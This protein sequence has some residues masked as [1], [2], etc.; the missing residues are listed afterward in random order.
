[1]N[2]VK[3]YQKPIMVGVLGVVVAI[4]L[5]ALLIAPQTSKLSSLNAQKST[6]QTQETQLQTRLTTLQAEKQALPTK[7]A[8]L[9]KITL[10]IPSVQ[11]PGDLA[12]EQAS[13]YNQLTALVGSSGT[14]IPSF[15]WTGNSPTGA[16]ATTATTTPAAGST[17]ATSGVVPVPVK[18][19]ITG[20]YGQ[21][22]SFIA[23]LDSFPRLFVIQSF[24]LAIGPG[25]A[26]STGST[27]ASATAANAPALWVGGSTPSGSAGPYGLDLTG[28][29]YYTATPS[30]L[31]AC[32]TA[33]TK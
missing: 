29:I 10:Q 12:A 9:Q 1:M 5:Y 16:A 27:G 33:T 24:T 19:H 21:M 31:A 8:S 15:A 7:C 4:L 14:S 26:A 13:F 11:N 6:L 3:E 17:P 30:A 28:S 23:G 20:N 32:N 18:M 22:S 2:T 25:S